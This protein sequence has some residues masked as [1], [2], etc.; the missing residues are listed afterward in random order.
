MIL[1]Y[2]VWL[3]T[4]ADSRIVFRLLVWNQKDLVC[5]NSHPLQM[6][7]VC[8]LWQTGQHDSDTSSHHSTHSNVSLDAHQNKYEKDFLW[9][10]PATAALLQLKSL[11]LSLSQTASAKKK[12]HFLP[13]PWDQIQY[14]ICNLQGPDGLAQTQIDIRIQNVSNKAKGCNKKNGISKPYKYRLDPQSILSLRWREGY[15]REQ[16][17]LTERERWKQRSLIPKPKT[18]LWLQTTCFRTLMRFCDTKG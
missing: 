12:S 16:A 1:Y 2:T 9:F 4:L 17:P 15:Q 3:A 7:S 6:L 18:E 14:G 13:K 8:C 10:W 5:L 11:L